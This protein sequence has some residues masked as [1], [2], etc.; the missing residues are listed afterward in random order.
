METVSQL[1][2]HYPDILG[3]GQEHFPEVFQ[4]L[5]FLILVMELGQ[6]RY[7]V[8]QEGHFVAKHHFDIVKG[9][10]RILHH[11]VKKGCNDTFGIHFKLCQ[12]V[13]HCQGM[14][15][16]GFPRGPDLGGMGLVRQFIG[17]PNGIEA[18]FIFNVG[19]DFIDKLFVLFFLLTGPVC[20][21]FLLLYILF[22]VNQEFRQRRCRCIGMNGLFIQV[23][24][25]YAGQIRSFGNNS[26]F[27]FRSFL[28]VLFLC[29][30]HVTHTFHLTDTYA[31][32]KPKK[33]GDPA[34]FLRF[35][36]GKN[37]PHCG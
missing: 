35:V 26:G 5:V 21:F 12:D 13:S 18:L 6:L 3:H 31:F 20:L 11:I 22:L 7:S 4:L 34:S 27:L 36:S 37:L 15:N 2:N 10:F 14:D 16:I 25:E 9:I 23:L 8:H 19:L 32:Y 24:V 33:T 28:Y 29:L 1:D 30:V 17:L